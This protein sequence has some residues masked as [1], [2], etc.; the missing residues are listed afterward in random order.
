MFIGRERELEA[1]EHM[2]AKQSFQMAVV[3]GRRRI[4][5]TA[6][7]N[8][9]VK[10]KESL[11]L[12]AEEVN[13]ALNLRKFSR[14]LGEM[15]GISDFPPVADWQAFFSMVKQQLGGR[16]VVVVI[17]EYPYAAAANKALS[18]TLQHAIDY[19]L[20]DSD[21]FLILCGSSMSFMEDQVL[22]EKSPLFGRRTGQLKINPLDYAEAAHFYPHASD[23]DKVNYYA[24][25][26]GTP[27]YLSLINPHLSFRENIHELYFTISGYLLNEGVLLMQ[28]EFREAANYNA[29]LQA[30]ASGSNTLNEIAGYTKLQNTFVSRYLVTLQ[31]LNYIQRIIPFDANPLKGKKSQYRISEN[32]IA[33]WYRYVFTVK[34]EIERGN[35]DLY[36]TLALEDL[37]TY[38]GHVFEEICRQ[39]LR[40]ENAQGHLPF[41]AKSFGT[42]WG[43]GKAGE[44]EE[45]DVVVESAESK[46]LIVGEC[47]WQSSDA[48]RKSLGK[49]IGLLQRRAALFERHVVH[50]YLFTKE[51]VTLS[52]DEQV[53]NIST[54]EL[55]ESQ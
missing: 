6:L 28:Q 30:I 55:F 53:V 15:M 34:P 22:G 47:K 2:Y 48:L 1:L 39:F 9:F 8:E 44:P 54:S 32:F 25:F 14:L 46:E 35:G 20:K 13:D 51:A 7:L 45:I 26:G 36:C 23:E 37:T 4:G 17:D 41:V 3:Y 12:P 42:W 52:R 38:V 27:Y 33:F 50:Q 43:K 11:Y 18:S 16:R 21:I 19:E 40:R 5:K 24:C 49:T 29:V 10:G 31:N